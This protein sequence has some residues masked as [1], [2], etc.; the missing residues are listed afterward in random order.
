MKDVNELVD[1]CLFDI[2][3]NDNIEDYKE[4][5]KNVISVINSKINY[6]ESSTKNEITECIFSRNVYCFETFRKYYY[7]K[8]VNYKLIS[9]DYFD[10]DNDFEFTTVEDDKFKRLL[11]QTYTAMKEMI[12]MKIILNNYDKRTSHIIPNLINIDYEGITDYNI[13]KKIMTCLFFKRNNDILVY[14]IYK[15]IKDIFHKKEAKLKKINEENKLFELEMNYSKYKY[16][17]FRCFFIKN[18]V[19]KYIILA[20]FSTRNGQP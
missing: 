3:L 7:N 9:Y 16:S 8:Y 6:V 11:F 14:S 12:K 4:K 17:R 20:N 1:L 10:T 13:F 19:R 18:F 15:K 2:D 5:V